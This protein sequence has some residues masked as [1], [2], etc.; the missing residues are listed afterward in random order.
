MSG[1][2]QPVRIR[3]PEGARI[4]LAREGTS[5]IAADYHEA[6][7]GLQIGPVYRFRLA[8][9][10][11]FPDVEIFPTVELI[12]RLYPPPGMALR[13]PIPVE[14][15]RDEIELAASGAFVTRV[16]YVENPLRALPVKQNRDSEQRWIEAPRG[17]DPLVV[18][19]RL[20]RAVA[21]LRMGGRVPSATNPGGPATCDSPPVMVYDAINEIPRNCPD[22]TSLV[23]LPSLKENRIDGAGTE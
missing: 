2:F 8:D 12:D 1:Y 4:A 16:I 3:A 18:A 5:T 22:A 10:P 14:L 13:Y 19:D 7:V 20:G 6:L 11:D 23:P 17:E 15:T 9:V 21:I